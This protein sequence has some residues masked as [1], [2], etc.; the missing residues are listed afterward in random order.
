VPSARKQ[1]SQAANAIVDE[2]LAAGLVGW[3]LVTVQA[4]ISS[5]SS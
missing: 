4:K 3:H 1:S 2:A 5:S